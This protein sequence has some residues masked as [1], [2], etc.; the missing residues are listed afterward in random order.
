MLGWLGASAPGVDGRS[1]SPE[2]SL[3]RA[4]G[5]TP[6]E[7]QTLKKTLPN[8][9]LAIVLLAVAWLATQSPRARFS[10]L[11]VPAEGFAEVYLQSE[12][13]KADKCLVGGRGRT[14]AKRSEDK[15]GKAS[16]RC[17]QIGEGPSI[18][19]AESKLEPSY[20]FVPVTQ[21]HD[22][23]FPLVYDS[24]RQELPL[25]MPAMRWVHF[26][27]HRQFQGLYLEIQLPARAFAA[28]NQLGRVELLAMADNRLLCFDRK[29]RPVCPI[30]NLALA[31]GILPMPLGND[32]SRR[33]FALAAAGGERQFVLSDTDYRL[34]YPMPMPVALHELLP[35]DGLYRDQRYRRWLDDD[36]AEALAVT[37]DEALAV[38][39]DAV[40]PGD[41]AAPPS[42][43]ALAAFQLHLPASLAATC[44]VMTCDAESLLSSLER[45]P[46]LRWLRR[47]GG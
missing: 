39:H 18:H 5:A 42:G 29:L 6:T 14:T 21:V 31:D 32:A 28:E 19:L 8:L 15:G 41:A 27:H 47:A 4:A 46:S 16:W 24:L 36:A 30:Y 26:F 34:L 44:E 12:P 17:R 45:S 2:P 43:D 25:P 22:L 33:L 9:L 13:G 10:N 35:R 11:K 3:H 40:T 38:R 1:C 7:T 23:A 37:S 20:L